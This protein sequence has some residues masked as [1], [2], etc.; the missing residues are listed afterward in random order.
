MLEN[1]GKYGK[2]GISVARLVIIIVAFSAVCVGFAIRLLYLQISEKNNYKDLNNSKY[3]TGIITAPRGEIYDRN[4]LTLVSNNICYNVDINRTTLASGASCEILSKLIDILSEHETEIADKCPLTYTQPYMLDGDYI[5]DSEKARYF[6]KFLSIHNITADKTSGENFYT[7]LTDYYDLPEELINT[8]KGRKIIGIRYDMEVNDFSSATPYTLIEN[9][10]DELRYLIA[11]H[12]HELHG[13]EISKSYTRYYN[14]DDTLCHILGR[15]G[16]IYAEEADEYIKEKGYPY[17]AYIGKDGVEK[18]YEEYLR[19]IDGVEGYNI[20]ENNNIVSHETVTEPKEGYCVRLTIDSKLQKIVEDALKDQVE[21]AVAYSRLEGTYFSGEDCKCGSAVVLDVNSGEIL[22]SA[23][24]PG[25]NMNTF[26]SEFESIRNSPGKPLINR[27][28]NGIYPPGSTFKILTAAAALDTGTITND[29]YI[30]DKGEYTKYAPT[31][32]PRCW[33]YLKSGATHGYVNVQEAIKVS[34][35]YFFYTVADQMGVETIDKYA[36]DFGLGV[37]TG[38]ELPESDGIL[39]TPEFKEKNG[40]VWSPG[41]TLQMAIGQSDNAFT[42]L[43]LAAYM[44]TVVNGGNRY[45]TTILKSVDEYYTGRHIYENKPEILNVTTLSQ[46][47]VES[48]KAGMKS[49][50]DDEGGT[51][52][53]VFAG[54]SYKDDIGGKTGTAQVTNGSDTVL[55]VGFMPFEDPDIAVAVVIENG[56]KSARAASVAAEIFDYY[57]AK[58]EKE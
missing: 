6:E 7:L 58:Y 53:T 13:I 45:K 11:E 29:T 21:K 44:S 35:N 52:K 28:F 26:S 48:L 15:V 47:T 34:C 20:D 56:Y 42:P 3:K 43:Q 10:P 4:G 9:V 57:Y 22:A 37:K 55:F 12:K 33:L 1:K 40:Y 14:L 50:V 19:G 31:Y 16:P 27:A 49:V 18:V 24:Y 2:S 17:D 36:L 25:F 39:A 46:S 32:T 38:V 54:K 23:S 51:A 30:Y 5:F 41:D 8:E